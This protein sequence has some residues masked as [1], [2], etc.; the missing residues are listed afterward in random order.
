MHSRIRPGAGSRAGRAW[1]APVRIRIYH[2]R[3]RRRRRRPTE[4]IHSDRLLQPPPRAKIKVTRPI[5]PP[6]VWLKTPIL[7]DAACIS[8]VH[9]IGRE[10]GHPGGAPRVDE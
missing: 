1:C 3:R 7:P 8:G 5:T 10:R 2:P 6:P 4:N 9:G